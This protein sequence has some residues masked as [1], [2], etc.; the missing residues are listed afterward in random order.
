[1]TKEDVKRILQAEFAKRSTFVNFHGINEANLGDFIV[2]PYQVLV[3]SDDGGETETRLMWVVLK[4]YRPN[5]N[6][7]LI[8]YDPLSKGWK[9]IEKHQEESKFAEVLG[10]DTFADALT[11]M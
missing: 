8:A 2:E 9:L 11:G 1:M 10:A 5:D 3:E 7:Y 6:G 4:E